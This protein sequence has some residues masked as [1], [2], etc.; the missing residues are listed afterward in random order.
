MHLSFKYY[1]YISNYKMKIFKINDSK[2]FKE[3]Y[4]FDVKSLNEAI[5]A[6]KYPLKVQKAES[7]D[8]IIPNYENKNFDRLKIQVI[9]NHDSSKKL[10][11]GYKYVIQDDEHEN[12]IPVIIPKDTTMKGG[13]I[14]ILDRCY[15]NIPSN[16]TE[17]QEKKSVG[18]VKSRPTQDAQTC[19][20]NNSVEVLKSSFELLK[21]IK[22]TELVYYILKSYKN[23]L[24]FFDNPND[25]SFISF[26]QIL[27]MKSKPSSLQPQHTFDELS[28]QFENRRQ[29]DDFTSFKSI[30][31]TIED[32]KDVE[33]NID[34]LNTKL[35]RLNKIIKKFVDTYVNKENILKV[36][37]HDMYLTNDDK[38]EVLCNLADMNTL[39]IYIS[40]LEKESV[41][42]KEG[43]GEEYSNYHTNIYNGKKEQIGGGEY[44]NILDNIYPTHIDDTCGYNSASLKIKAEFQHDFKNL[45]FNALLQNEKIF[46]IFKTCPSNRVHE[47]EYLR[48]ILTSIGQEELSKI[49][50]R[51][52]INDYDTSPTFL[53]T[54]KLTNKS[55]LVDGSIATEVRNTISRSDDNLN[56]I[57]T[58]A[59][60]FDAATCDTK[61]IK[62]LFENFNKDVEVMND[63]SLNFFKMLNGPYLYFISFDNELKFNI[64]YMNGDK[65]IE[66][67]YTPSMFS[68][69]EI[70][71]CVSFDKKNKEDTLSQMFRDVQQKYN[72]RELAILFLTMCKS[73]GD[74]MQIMFAKLYK[75]SIF[76]SQDVNAIASAIA[77]VTPCIFQSKAQSLKTFVDHIPS[78]SREQIDSLLGN[79]KMNIA[80]I[81]FGHF[82]DY[83]EDMD[84]LKK[85]YTNQYT[86]V[87]HLPPQYSHLSDHTKIQSFNYI[88]NRHIN[89]LYLI[90][91]GTFEEGNLV[92]HH[93]TIDKSLYDDLSKIMKSVHLLDD[94]KYQLDIQ[95]LFK[96]LQSILIVKDNNAL[97]VK[98]KELKFSILGE[99]S[100]NIEKPINQYKLI[101]LVDELKKLLQRLSSIKT[102]I[103]SIISTE[104]QQILLNIYTKY[105]NDHLLSNKEYISNIYNALEKLKT[106]AKSSGYDKP[107]DKNVIRQVKIVYD[108]DIHALESIK[109]KTISKKKKY[110]VSIAQAKKTVK[111]SEIEETIQVYRKDYFY[112]NTLHTDISTIKEFLDDMPGAMNNSMNTTS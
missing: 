80:G 23:Y 52:N 50:L 8:N 2:L 32:F 48:H 72:D 104:H 42:K 44:S 14:V 9:K 70:E 78:T 22:Q 85:L 38:I 108:K 17:P 67:T 51:L 31:S 16:L 3:Y 97:Y 101:S 27:K 68:I 96:R 47:S 69:L 12:Y 99:T 83:T 5:Y 71:N 55:I 19:V 75:E 107:Y 53:E 112:I 10:K 94:I 11:D 43:G 4:T 93:K 25:A 46:S 87:L 95:T 37:F 41:T 65:S 91:E 76:V 1:S 24:I 30:L 98:T 111:M 33:E 63:I 21:K 106:E 15:N 6:V 90:D 20:R 36:F 57:I 77:T 54:H 60:Y 105:F 34:H 58:L 29:A 49:R 61:N 74:H 59:K 89:E 88:V 84:W 81:Y 109:N 64:K 35:T 62:P 86:N 103:V 40:D 39:D 82:N 110:K 26:R 13:R 92:N 73:L 18:I 79:R 45:D 100:P 7:L 66:Y 28:S 56:E 102:E